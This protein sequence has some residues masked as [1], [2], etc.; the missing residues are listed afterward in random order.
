VAALTINLQMQSP[1]PHHIQ[2]KAAPFHQPSSSPKPKFTMAFTT[3][4]QYPTRALCP[5]TKPNPKLT[6]STPHHH[7]NSSA[8]TPNHQPSLFPKANLPS[9]SPYTQ[10][11]NP[12]L[13]SISP[14]LSS[15][16]N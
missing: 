15:S 13:K 14:I 7:R 3:T 8:S 9:S 6:I 16:I 2:T 1:R 11:T 10:T 4:N 5:S 12:H